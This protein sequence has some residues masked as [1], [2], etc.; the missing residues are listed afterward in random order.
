[1]NESPILY[2]GPFYVNLCEGS[3]PTNLIS[4]LS[5]FSFPHHH[6]FGVVFSIYTKYV[7]HSHSIMDIEHTRDGSNPSDSDDSCVVDW[8]PK[9]GS[10]D[11]GLCWHHYKKYGGER[12]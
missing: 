3:W 11:E 2:K 7:H 12:K 5:S 6:F 1:M 9:R 10:G 8:C 4:S